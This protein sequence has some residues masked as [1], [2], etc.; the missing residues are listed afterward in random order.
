MSGRGDEARGR[1]RRGNR[2]Y[3]ITSAAVA[4][5]QVCRRAVAARSSG[6]ARNQLTLAHD[7]RQQDKGRSP[8]AVR[9]G[10]AAFPFRPAG[11]RRRPLPQGARDR[12]GA[13]RLPASARPDPRARKS[14]RPR[15]RFHR[16][17]DPQQPWQC[18]IF[19]QSRQPAGA[20]QPVRRGAEELRS[21][22]QAQAGSRQCLDQARRSPAE[23]EARRRGVAHLRPRAEL[24]TRA[25]SRRPT[26]AACC[27]WRWAVTA[28]RW[29]SSSCRIRSSRTSRTPF[30]TRDFA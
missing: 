9:G 27:C 24:S 19:L 21:R 18:R 17:G 22:A 12:S 4:K 6:M 16:A 29:Q 20:A 13:C 15:H 30:T 1:P 11:G 28:R 10:A 5:P 26:R 7:Q 2:V 8:G 3:S 23:A 14:R 25:A